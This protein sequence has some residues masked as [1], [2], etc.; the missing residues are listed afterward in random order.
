MTR[1]KGF[2]VLDSGETF[3][4]LWRGEAGIERAGEVVF[5]TSHSGY[6]ELA[7]DPSYFSQ[8]VVLTAPQQGNYG[9]SD[10]CWESEKIW[11]DGFVCVEMQKCPGATAPGAKN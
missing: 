7:T 2:L 8:I 5:N 4:G 11:I 6:E 10:Q 1:E 3:P 9:E